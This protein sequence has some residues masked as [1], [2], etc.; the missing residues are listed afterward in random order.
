M[1]LAP[2]ESNYAHSI[3][4]T[5]VGNVKHEKKE[6]L[7]K[8]ERALTIFAIAAFF[9]QVV[10]AGFGINHSINNIKKYYR[11]ATA[12][13]IEIAQDTAT[14]VE[15]AQPSQT[16]TTE[17]IT[18]TTAAAE[19]IEAMPT[20]ESLEIDDSLLSDPEALMETFVNGRTT[21]WFNAGSTL[22]NAR[23][24]FEAGKSGKSL[25]TSAEEIAEKYDVLFIDALLV[26]DWKSNPVM[27]EW[28]NRMIS[29]HKTTLKLYF[30]TSFPDVTPEDKTPYMRGSKFTQINS[31]AVNKDGS[32]TIS[33]TE[34]DY[35]NADL[36]RVGEELTNG[37]K[38]KGERINSTSTFIEVDG[39][40]KLSNLTLGTN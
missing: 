14:T 11:P 37:T 31:S 35:D 1:T 39:K 18:T 34:H 36:N 29:V 21:E 5:G 7:T 6:G 27:A 22:E 10:G 23:A 38:V 24:A 26:K 17:S 40:V 28:V 4:A 13:N 19:A 32:V 2:F 20:V 9:G 3:E 33:S 12:T 8:K 25:E 30:L 15:T 16:A